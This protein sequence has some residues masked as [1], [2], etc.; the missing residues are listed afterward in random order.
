MTLEQV[1]NMIE[2][3]GLPFVYYQFELG[4]APNPPYVIFYYPERKDF[5]AD[6]KAFQKIAVLNI[7]LYSDSKDFGKEKLIEDM[8]EEND[9]VYQKEEQFIEDE[10][11]Y[12]V[13]YTTEV[14]INES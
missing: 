1:A 2:G 14:F 7:E 6:N 9:L 11:L 5:Q 13:L 12:E 4:E 8:L 10:N 3:L